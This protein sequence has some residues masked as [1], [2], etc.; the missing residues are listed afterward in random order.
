MKKSDFMVLLIAVLMVGFVFEKE[1]HLQKPIDSAQ[2][3]FSTPLASSMLSVDDPTDFD[4]PK[5]KLKVV[6]RFFLNPGITAIQ[7]GTL[8][9]IIDWDGLVSTNLQKFEGVVVRHV[10]KKPLLEEFIHS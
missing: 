3:K 9:R 8:M 10:L 7:Q 5:S 2:I 1:K 4:L 6:D